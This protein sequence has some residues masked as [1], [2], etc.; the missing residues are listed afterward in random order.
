MLINGV[1]VLEYIAL[2]TNEHGGIKPRKLSIGTNDAG[3]AVL[4]YE[5]QVVPFERIR[6]KFSLIVNF[7]FTK[8]EQYDIIML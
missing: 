7:I 5:L 2:L 1:E 4:D 6:R 3:Q 8:S